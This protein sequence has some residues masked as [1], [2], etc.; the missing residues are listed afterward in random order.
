MTKADIAE[1]IQANTGMSKKESLEMLD[2]V[3]SIMKNTLEV[4]EKIKVSGFGNFEVKQKK[5]RKGRNPQTGDAITIEARRILSFKP[6]AL[7]REA[8]NCNEGR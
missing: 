1:R 2:G 5:D 4:G 3:F 7:L 8:I 6:S